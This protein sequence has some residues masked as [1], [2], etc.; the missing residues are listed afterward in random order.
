MF[1]D[2]PPLVSTRRGLPDPPPPT[3]TG[4]LD[5]AAVLPQAAVCFDAL[6]PL[7]TAWGAGD[8]T[9][10]PPPPA[11][12]RGGA[13]G[14][15]R[16]HE[17]AT[18]G[19][20]LSPQP[21]PLPLPHDAASSPPPPPPP[22]PPL[23]DAELDAELPSEGFT[24]VF[25]PSS[26][27]PADTAATGAGAAKGGGGLDVGALAAAAEWLRSAT[28]LTCFGFDVVVSTANDSDSAAGGGS[29]EGERGVPPRDTYY[30]VDVNALPTCARVGGAREALANALIAAARMQGAAEA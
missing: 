1:G 2:S 16:Q 13:T 8:Q 10:P 22:P 26:A 15:Q 18:G 21:P 3:R 19:G 24:T 6:R 9:P 29:G 27:A 11:P 25:P 28:G 14:D 20:A 5:G 23:S 30:V 4:A 17:G 7:P 12:E